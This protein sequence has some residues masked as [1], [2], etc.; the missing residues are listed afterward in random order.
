MTDSFTLYTYFRSS[1][2][3]RVRIALNL[4]GIEADYRFVHLLNDGGRQHDSDYARLN[5]Q[6][7]V[8]TL[9]HGDIALGQS[10]AI[11]EYLEE[12]KPE[13][14][15]LP[16]DTSGRAR[17]RQIAD[18][19]ACDIHPL[20]NLRVVNYLRETLGR[21]DEAVAAWMKHW[22]C[23]GFDAIEKMLSD[24]VRTGRFC[25]GNAPTI[26]DACL[27]PQMANARRTHVDLNP[28]PTLMRIEDAALELPA[29]EKA[30]PKNQPDA[31]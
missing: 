20:N 2:A 28:Y 13:P 11:M 6:E 22:I 17:V 7:I 21:N 15:L 4:K 16:Q 24:D 8:P 27:I 1:A 25:H 29:F 14:P 9:R 23:L 19:V 26:A 10:L 30:L 18:A 5:P 31:E 3:F 12:I